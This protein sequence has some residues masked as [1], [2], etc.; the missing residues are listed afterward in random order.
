M[1]RLRAAL[2]TGLREFYAVGHDDVISGLASEIDPDEDR[3][4]ERPGSGV[5]LRALTTEERED[6]LAFFYGGVGDARHVF[7]TLRDVYL[8]CSGLRSAFGAPDAAA[9]SSSSSGSSSGGCGGGGG[10]G[11]KKKKKSGKGKRGSTSTSTSTTM[12]S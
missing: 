5:D 2:W 10:G 7:A 12:S 3:P 11:S 4:L 8:Q 1:P 6:G 9:A